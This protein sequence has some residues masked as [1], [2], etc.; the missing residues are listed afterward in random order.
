MLFVVEVMQEAGD[1]PKLLVLAEFAG[2]NREEVYEG[3]EE[4]GLPLED[5]VANVIEAMQ[6]NAEALGLSGVPVAN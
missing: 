2:M 6:G 5:H 3:A 1:A 4:I